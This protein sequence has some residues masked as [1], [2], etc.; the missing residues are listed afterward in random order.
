[1]TNL[2]LTRPSLCFRWNWIEWQI[3][4]FNMWANIS[5]SK[6]LFPCIFC[7]HVLFYLRMKSKGLQIKFISLHVYSLLFTDE[8]KACKFI[9]L[10][11]HCSMMHTVESA[12]YDHVT[13][14]CQTRIHYF[15][16]LPY[17]FQCKSNSRDV[18]N[19]SKKILHV[20]CMYDVNM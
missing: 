10:H 19:N 12:K 7:I 6:I 20:Q 17:F 13:K 14:I 2:W 4:V 5:D 9:D 16:I 18:S 3:Y 8:E 1:M 11:V 15:G